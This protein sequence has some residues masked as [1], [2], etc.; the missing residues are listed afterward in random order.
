MKKV[1]D[2]IQ[3]AERVLAEQK[4]NASAKLAQEAKRHQEWY[5]AAAKLDAILST[6][7]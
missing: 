7:Q 5:E 6:S 1:G 4:S 3:A 2:E